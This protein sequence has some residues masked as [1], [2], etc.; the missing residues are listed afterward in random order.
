MFAQRKK[1]FTFASRIYKKVIINNLQG[2]VL[3]N[4]SLIVAKR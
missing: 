2:L 4:I 1:N 3:S